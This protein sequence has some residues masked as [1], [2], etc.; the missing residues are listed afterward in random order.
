[1]FNRRQSG[2]T[3]FGSSFN[4]STVIQVWQKGGLVP[5]QD[6]AYVRQDSCGAYIYWADY[7][8]TS[9]QFGWEIDHIFPVSKGGQDDLQNLQPL[10]WENNRHKG[11]SYPHLAC[12][13]GH[14]SLLRGLLSL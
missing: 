1:M 7:G 14:P 9:S 4:Q 6:P 13:I 10:Q 11:D 3:K 5:G 8:N 2:Q 12:K